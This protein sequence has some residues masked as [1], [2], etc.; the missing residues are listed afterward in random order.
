VNQLQRYVGSLLL[1][2]SLLARWVSRLPVLRQVR[3]RKSTFDGT[4]TVSTAIGITG[5]TTKPALTGTG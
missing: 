4:T 2:A 5:M 1:G 3:G